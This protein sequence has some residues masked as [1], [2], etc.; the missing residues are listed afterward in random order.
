[1]SQVQNRRRGKLI[2][3]RFQV[4]FVAMAVSVLVTLALGFLV[5]WSASGPAAKAGTPAPQG[6]SSSLALLGL[7]VLTLLLVMVTVIFGIRFSHRI[8]GPI[9]AFN[10]NMNWVKEGNYTRDLKLRDGDEFQNLAITFNAMQSALR[11]RTRDDLDT[12][13]RVQSTLT[14]VK[15]AAQSGDYDGAELLRA[16]EAL[17]KDLVE[18]HKRNEKLLAG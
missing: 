15:S 6:E 9:Y 2:D 5:L 18:M 12:V 8:V 11:R 14:E 17:D 13:E 7:L 16:L 3:K 4:K 10:R 1:M